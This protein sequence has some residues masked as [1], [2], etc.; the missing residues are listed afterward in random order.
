MNAICGLRQS[1]AFAWYDHGTHSWRTS[2]GCLLTGTFSEFSETWMKQGMMRD[3]VC[4]EQTIV[5]Q[6]TEENGYGFWPTP[7]ST[8]ARQGL[9]IRREGKKGTQQ[10]LS[11]MVRFYPTPNVSDARM[12]NN[13]NNHDLIRGYL[14]SEAGHGGQLNPNWVEWLMGWPV[15]WTDLK[16]LAMDK[17][18]SWLKQFGDY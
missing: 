5:E 13:K 17:F 2:Q 14:R 11:T 4:W 8:E 10:S 18:Q 16:P 9:Q 7:Q 6:T 12:C 15:G 3:G 1:D